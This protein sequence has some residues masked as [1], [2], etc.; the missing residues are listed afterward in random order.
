M[1]WVV[2]DA[3]ETY[4]IRYSLVFRKT[5]WSEYSE[6][7]QYDGFSYFNIHHTICGINKRTVIYNQM[8]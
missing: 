8:P 1:T 5:K 4:F 3:N 7:L 2:I 6:V